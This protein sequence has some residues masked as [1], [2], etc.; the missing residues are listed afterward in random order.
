MPSSARKQNR[1]CFARETLK[2]CLLR[3]GSGGQ[4][5]ACH[6]VAVRRRVKAVPIAAANEAQ[7]RIALCWTYPII[8]RGP[9]ANTFCSGGLLVLHSFSEG[10]GP[11]KFP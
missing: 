1:E 11:P 3:R 2:H 7:N 5:S 4:G 6:A 10:G 9:R 8:R